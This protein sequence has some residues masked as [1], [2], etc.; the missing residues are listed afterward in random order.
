MTTIDAPTSPTG[1]RLRADAARNQQRIL[2][3]AQELFALRGLDI[4]LDDVAAHAGVGVGTVYRRFA[5]K[6]ELIDGVFE[7]GVNRMSESAELALKTDNAWDGL[8][9]YF[10]Y[11]LHNFACSRGFAEVVKGSTEGRERFTS[12]RDRMRPAVEELIQRAKD[13][14]SLRT[15]AAPQDFFAMIFMVDS[16][17]QFARQVNPEVWRRY[18]GLVLDGLRADGFAREP[19]TTPPMTDRQIETA[20]TSCL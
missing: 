10:E 12:M 8:V 5:N 2:E 4:S 16:I 19:I 9:N 6:Q 17:A 13:E 3:A 15:D 14:G 20:K 18:F 7:D 1:R 11:V